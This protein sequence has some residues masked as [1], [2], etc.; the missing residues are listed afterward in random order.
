MLNVLEETHKEWDH[1]VQKKTASNW[2]LYVTR[3]VWHKPST[4][5]ITNL[6]SALKNKELNT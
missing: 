1:M 3:Q 5:R 4:D 6:G 2:A